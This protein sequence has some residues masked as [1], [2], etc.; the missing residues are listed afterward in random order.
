M[1]LGP[2]AGEIEVG[3]GRALEGPVWIQPGM[4]DGVVG[5]TLGY[6]RPRP[7]RV[8]RGSGYNAYPLRTSTHPYLATG[9]TLALTGVD[10]DKKPVT[11][12][13][14]LVKEGGAWKMVKEDWKM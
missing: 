1:G 12:T 3:I 13:A 10:S 8:G 14:D 5:V 11:G 7:G 2:V 6:G 4:A 9:A